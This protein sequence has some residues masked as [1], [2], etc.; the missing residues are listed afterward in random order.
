MGPVVRRLALGGGVLA[1]GLWMLAAHRGD[2]RTIEGE[3]TRIGDDTVSITPGPGLAARLFQSRRLPIAPVLAQQLRTGDRIHAELLP[4]PDGNL[5]IDQIRFLHRT[6]PPPEPPPDDGSLRSGEILPALA[7]PGIEGSFPLGAGQGT[8]TVLAFLFTTC[9]I[10]S[11]CP[12]VASKLRRLQDEIRGQ[13]RIVTITLDPDK[14]SLST[15]REYAA[16]QK[17]DRDTWKLGRLEDADLSP[18]LRRI[19]IVRIKSDTQLLHSLQLVLLDG[20]GRLVWRSEGSTWE[21]MDLA[22]RVNALSRG[23]RS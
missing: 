3:V 8:P 2:V 14:D 19:G 5:R 20:Q 11:A 10:P 13:G 4:S 21:V 17:A 9:G 23:R 22:A 7:V 1:V 15:L 18:L 12:M 6:T 16:A